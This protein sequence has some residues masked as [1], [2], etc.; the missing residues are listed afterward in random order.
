[1]IDPW[2][3]VD[4]LLAD[5]TFVDIALAALAVEF[6][7]ALALIGAGRLALRPLDLVGHLLA[8][9]LLLLALRVAVTGADPRW[10]LGLLAASL[11][12]HGYDL[13][14]RASRQPKGPPGPVP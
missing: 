13:V 14:R 5:G 9:G 8:G 7:V 3:T 12:A 6:V 1:M 10:I 2:S 4:T 11:P